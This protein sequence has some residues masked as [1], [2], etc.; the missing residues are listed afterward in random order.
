MRHPSFGWELETESSYNIPMTR[1][2]DGQYIAAQVLWDA[3]DEQASTPCQRTVNRA[4][5]DA[6]RLDVSVVGHLFVF[7]VRRM[8]QR[9]RGLSHCERK[10]FTKKPG[11]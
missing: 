6:L 5:G 4:G 2:G 11:V 10:W 3:W 7:V 8:R 1:Y 9:R